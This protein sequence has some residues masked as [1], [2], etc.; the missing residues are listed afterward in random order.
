MSLR[1]GQG[2]G[3][4]RNGGMGV[5]LEVGVVESGT[6]WQAA[7]EIVVIATP[8]RCA[9]ARKG[10]IHADTLAGSCATQLRQRCR[11]G[12]SSALLSHATWPQSQDRCHAPIDNA[13]TTHT[14]THTHSQLDLRDQCAGNTHD[15]SSSNFKIF[16]VI[17]LFGARN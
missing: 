9:L 5:A 3:R 4:E 17:S 6:F 13:L 12:V 11:G 15:C 7:S 10:A 14:H 1:L 16:Y 8:T 2:R